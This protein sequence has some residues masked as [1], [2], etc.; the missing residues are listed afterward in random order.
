VTGPAAALVGLPAPERSFAS[1]NTAGVHPA[2]LEALAAANAG[3]VD[4]YGA[5]PWTARLEALVADLFGRP[6]PLALCFGG[7]GANV[8]ALHTLCRPGSRIVCST[9]A[10]VLLDEADAPVHATGT[11]YLPLPTDATGKITPEALATARNQLRRLRFHDPAVPHVLSLTQATEAGT[12]YTPDELAVLCDEAHRAGMAV[13]VDGARLSNALVT[14]GHGAAGL[15]EG[16]RTLAATGVDVVAFGGTKAGLMGAELLLFCNPAVA[17]PVIHRR[18]QITQTASKMRFLAAQFLA[19]LDGG[20]IL[21]WSGRANATARRLGDELAAIDGV[22]LAFPVEANA[23]FATVPA[24]ATAA[25]AA[26]TPFHW[27]DA[28]ETLARLVTSWD[29]SDEDVD[30]L[31]AGTRAAVSAGAA[32]PDRREDR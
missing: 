22:G 10:H 3:H 4:A 23:V 7:T 14:W 21:D 16:C 19:A 8:V 18:K 9:D 28:R 17:D 25:L 6:V 12:T 29:T 32:A 5:D 1:D 30:R 20:A 11:Q 26:W 31:V 24:A 15:A 13:H 27:W 2:V